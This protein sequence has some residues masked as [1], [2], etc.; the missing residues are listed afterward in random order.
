MLV[1]LRLYS[2]T[3]PLLLLLAGLLTY[4]KLGRVSQSRYF[5]RWETSSIMLS[6][7]QCQNTELMSNTAAA[8]VTPCQ[9]ELPESLN[10]R[11]LMTIGVRLLTGYMPFLPPTTSTF[12]VCLTSLFYTDY[13]RLGHVPNRSSIEEPLRITDVRLLQAGWSACYPTNNVR[14]LKVFMSKMSK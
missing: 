12:S 4:H 2:A 6:N 13:S 1:R 9:V 5:C 14:A 8:A 10:K 11:T 7:K 3:K